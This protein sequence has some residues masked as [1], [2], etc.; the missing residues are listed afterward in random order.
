VGLTSSLLNG[1]SG[2]TDVTSEDVDAVPP[3][4]NTAVVNSIIY[5][6]PARRLHGRIESS[7]KDSEAVTERGRK[8]SNWGFEICRSLPDVSTVVQVAAVWMCS[9]LKH[10]ISTDVTPYVL[11]IVRWRKIRRARCKSGSGGVA[12]V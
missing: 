1:S 10:E 4:W 3:N 8:P 5:L 6:L 11:S 9:N 12:L 2:S 7:V